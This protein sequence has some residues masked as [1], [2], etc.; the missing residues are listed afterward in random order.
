MIYN[1]SFI[2]ALEDI[3]KLTP[4]NTSN[5]KNDELVTIVSTSYNMLIKYIHSCST[6]YYIFYSRNCELNLEQI[7]MIAEKSNFPVPYIIIYEF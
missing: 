2:N 3:I 5:I 7:Y 1:Q 6:K 4:S